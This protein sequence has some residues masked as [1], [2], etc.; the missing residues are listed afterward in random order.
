MAKQYSIVG[1][2][3]VKAE[4]FIKTLAVGTEVVLVREPTNAF[5][6]N[7][8]AIWAE[9]RKVG[10][11]PKKSNAILAAFIDQSGRAWMPPG[12][13]I[14]VGE[15]AQDQSVSVHIEGSKAIDGKFFRSPNSAFPMVEV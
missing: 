10:Y 13:E 1:S 7:A 11:V 4:E 12:A 3:F 15:L 8:V 14:T 9:G 2:N 6:P 5:D